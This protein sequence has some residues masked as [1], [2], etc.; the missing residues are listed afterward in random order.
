[1]FKYQNEAKSAVRSF[2]IYLSILLSTISV[3]HGLFVDGSTMSLTASF[4][5]S[6]QCTLFTVFFIKICIRTNADTLSLSMDCEWR[7]QI[8]FLFIMNSMESGIYLWSLL[9]LPNTNRIDCHSHSF[10]AYSGIDVIQILCTIIAVCFIK[11]K[12]N[13]Q[14]QKVS[15]HHHSIHNIAIT[16]SALIKPN[17]SP[18]L[19]VQS[20]SA[21][22]VNPIPL[23]ERH[24]MA[25]IQMLQKSHQL[26]MLVI[27]IFICALVTA[28]YTTWNVFSS[29]D[30]ATFVQDNDVLNEILRLIA[31]ITWLFIPSWLIIYVF[32]IW[33]IRPKKYVSDDSLIR[34]ELQR[35]KRQ[36]MWNRMCCL[37]LCTQDQQ[38]QQKQYSALQCD[39]DALPVEQKEVKHKASV[40]YEADNRIVSGYH[41]NNLSLNMDQNEYRLYNASLDHH[42]HIDNGNDDATSPDSSGSMPGSDIWD[43]HVTT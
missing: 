6:V 10:M 35:Q 20:M 30:C 37:C 2:I 9:T 28:I 17:D 40:N 39:D 21:L 7:F 38:Q 27:F 14:H 34:R 3:L 31:R 18:A 4:L 8:V 26:L 19:A 29:R 25:Q 23:P 32:W 22:Q 43:Q 15:Y 11:R 42:A 1:M 24:N 33:P 13:K 36:R 41:E 5:V 12:I 16:K